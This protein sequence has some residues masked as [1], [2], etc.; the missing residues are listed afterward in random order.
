MRRIVIS[1]EVRRLLGEKATQQFLT[2]PPFESF[3]CLVCGKKGS[4]AAGRD[5][6]LSLEVSGTNMRTRITHARCAPSVVVEVP[7]EVLTE[8]MRDMKAKRLLWGKTPFFA[9][10]PD[11]PAFGMEEGGSMQDVW[12]EGFKQ[13]G[14]VVLS[15]SAP[16][17][18]PLDGWRLEISDQIYALCPPDAPTITIGFSEPAGPWLEA[19]WQANACVAITGTTLFIEPGELNEDRLRRQVEQGQAVAGVVKVVRRD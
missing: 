14:F 12:L 11:S 10:G 9:F 16:P 7:P 4:F 1:P 15:E 8:R 6:A 2:S 17:M 3:E 5:V 18:I 19:V 13:M